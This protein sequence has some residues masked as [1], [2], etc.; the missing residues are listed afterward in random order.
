MSDAWA[1]PK[2]R[3][4]RQL[5]DVLT[6]DE[7]N[8]LLAAPNTRTHTGLR[9]RAIMEVMLRCGLRVSE[10]CD[11]RADAVDLDTGWIHVRHGKRDKSRDIAIGP[12]LAPW[13]QR[14]A[15]TRPDSPYF[16]CSVWSGHTTGTSPGQRLSRQAIGETSRRYAGKAGVAPREEGMHPARPHGFRHKFATEAVR[17]GVSVFVLQKLMGHADVATT[18]IYLHVESRDVKD[19]MTQI[20]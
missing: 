18:G 8:R 2:P 15:E 14:W 13:L 3:K 16:F 4:Q 1:E 12:R 9:D 5:P 6:D 11:L 19:A 7:V 17:A 20:G 10:V